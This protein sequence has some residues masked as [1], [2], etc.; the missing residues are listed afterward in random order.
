M[1][2]WNP[3][4]TGVRLMR[5]FL[6]NNSA[7]ILFLLGLGFFRTAVA[8]WSPIPSESM[9]PTIFP[10]DVVLVNK[11]VLGPAIPFTES[12]VFALDQPARG[13]IITF[14]SPIEDK[15]YI[16]RVIGVPGDHIR[17]RGVRVYVNDQPLDLEILDDGRQSGILQA[18][19]TIDGRSHLMQ[20]NLAWEINEQREELVVPP[21]SYFVMGDYRNNSTD[22]RVFGPI[23]QDSILGRATRIMVSIADERNP[24]TSIGSK[25]H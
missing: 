13:D 19:E 15:V 1:L 25:L 17:T 20:A 9:E 12:R 3:H 16:K 22:S 10:G 7:F 2:S 14:Q 18:R 23:H 4:F 24:V 6:K 8:D 5:A 21:D 11:T